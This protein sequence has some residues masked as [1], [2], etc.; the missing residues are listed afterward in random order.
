MPSGGE[1]RALEVRSQKTEEGERPTMN[2]CTGAPERGRR[3]AGRSRHRGGRGHDVP[4]RHVTARGRPG[5]QIS[6]GSVCRPARSAWAASRPT[7]AVS[8]TSTRATRS[9]FSQPFELMGAEVT[10]GQ[11]ARFVTD[12]GYP[13][14]P[15]PEYRQTDRHPVGPAELGTMRSPSAPGPGVVYPPRPSGST[16]A[17]GGWTGQVYGWGNEVSRDRANYGADQCCAGGDRW[18]RTGG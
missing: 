18:R 3:C 10:V 9:R 7:P 12:T 17:R 14:P 5:G 4:R 16:A 2:P 8:T 6:A 15:P 13:S 11:Y 1:D